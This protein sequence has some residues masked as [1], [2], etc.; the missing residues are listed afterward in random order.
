MCQHCDYS[1]MLSSMGM[2]PTPHRKRVLEVI[3]SNSCP[4]SV[5]EIYETLARSKSI[6][7]VTVYRILDN[8][9][10]KG[11]VDRLSGGSRAA[12]YGLAPN[13]NHQPHPHF[14]CKR[15]GQMNC[16]N[17]GSIVMDMEAFQQMFPGRID[18][19]E[20]RVDGLCKNCLRTH[21]KAP[22]LTVGRESS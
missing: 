11:L 5:Q 7:R 22:E 21:K 3:G 17:P 9:V 18:G 13:E 4:L 1:D 8:L 20:V 15:C 14:Y 12:H 19:V 10:E 16:L 2:T 6:N